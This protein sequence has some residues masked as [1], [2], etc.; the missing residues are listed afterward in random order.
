[1]CR[2]HHHFPAEKTAT[3][4]LMIHVISARFLRE[5]RLVAC[6]RV[7]SSCSEMNSMIYSSRRLRKE[8]PA[9]AVTMVNHHFTLRA[10]KAD[11]KMWFE[12]Q[13]HQLI[14]NVQNQ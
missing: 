3:N 10:K 11:P 5:I 2:L 13:S 12:S 6:Q 14:K 4:C 7:A 9:T 8:V 1:M